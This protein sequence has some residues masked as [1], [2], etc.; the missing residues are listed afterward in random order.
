MSVSAPVSVRYRRSAENVTGQGYIE[1]VSEQR[2][3]GKVGRFLPRRP[4]ESAAEMTSRFSV[5]SSRRT[6]YVVDGE[7]VPAPDD[8]TIPAALAFA[9]AELDWIALCLFPSPSEA[10]IT[11]LAEPWN[12]HPLLV[13]DLHRGGQ[14]PKLERYGDVLFTV[15]RRL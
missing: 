12:L 9:Q 4:S 5:P 13:K 7:L 11:E 1:D 14:R 6:R 10:D 15:I 8:A 2:H 3:A